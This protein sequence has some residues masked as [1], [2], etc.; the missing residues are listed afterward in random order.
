MGS[1]WWKENLQ[2]IQ[3]Y[4]ALARC[5]LGDGR[6]AYF[7]ND[8]WAEELM[9]HKFPHL[10]SY[11]INKR[12][13]IHQVISRD[14]LEDLF[15][16]PLSM[17]AHEQFFKLEDICYTLR[18]SQYQNLTDTWSYIWGNEHFSLAKAYNVMIGYKQTPPHFNWMWNSSCQ[19]KHKMFFWMLLH[20][21][22]S[23]IHLLRRKTFILE[24]YNCSVRE[25]QQEETL[26]HLFWDVLSPRDAGITFV[27][28]K[29]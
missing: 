11:V 1:F 23:I 22:L 7:W 25:C 9:Q 4:K 21:R 3:Q 26:H 29:H 18:Q 14:Y 10:F 16:L 19:P 20:D 12:L 2:L 5:N 17:E 15:H 24:E 6:T 27:P 8:L 28:P 13:T